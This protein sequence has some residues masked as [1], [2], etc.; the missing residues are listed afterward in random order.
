MKTVPLTQGYV[1]LVD[2]WDHWWLSQWKWTADVRANGDVY[3]RRVA[4]GRKAPHKIYMHRVILQASSGTLVDHKDRNPLNN[5]RD[6]LRFATRAENRANGVRRRT[7]SGRFKGV[8][9]YGAT[10]WEATIKVDGSKRVLG[11]FPTDVEAARAY[12]TAVL[13]L[14]GQPVVLN[15][16]TED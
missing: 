16:P 3:A 2:D 11:R 15:F 7:S 9:K 10:R 12:D 8:S 4:G 1:A 6:N 14:Y 5:Q 13:A